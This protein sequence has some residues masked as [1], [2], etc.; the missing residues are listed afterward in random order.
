MEPMKIKT[1][2]LVIFLLMIPIISFGWL[3]VLNTNHKPVCVQDGDSVT[4]DV[5]GFNYKEVW[6][7]EENPDPR[8]CDWPFE[9]HLSME[10]CNSTMF[11]IVFF[12][13]ASLFV[14]WGIYAMYIMFLWNQIKLI[15]MMGMNDPDYHPLQ[16]QVDSPTS[17]L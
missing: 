1:R 8:V 13:T 12:L 4:Y 10:K 7:L 6:Y 17:G 15:Q 3:I 14:G 11:G 16:L 2:N 9:T 5:A